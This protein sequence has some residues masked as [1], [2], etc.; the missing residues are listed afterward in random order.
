MI[1]ISSILKETD[2]SPSP[3]SY[4]LVINW[5]QFVS[6]G[7]PG[8]SQF[9]VH[10]DVTAPIKVWWG[11]I[12]WVTN[13]KERVEGVHPCDGQGCWLEWGPH[14]LEMQYHKIDPPKNISLFRLSHF[15][16]TYC[17]LSPN[18][19]RRSLTN[20]G[21]KMAI[22]TKMRFSQKHVWIWWESTTSA[23]NMKFGQVVP[24]NNI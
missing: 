21:Q 10:R 17:M 8:F 22:S 1:S 9:S 14:C 13:R 5:L 16:E 23:R 11:P 7:I 24:F 15:T 19:I 4:T 2:N 6:F 18:R 20:L 12:R 3:P